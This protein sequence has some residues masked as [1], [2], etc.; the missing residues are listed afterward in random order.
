[1]FV[2]L[3][4]QLPDAANILTIPHSFTAYVNFTRST[5]GPRWLDCYSP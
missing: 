1:M 2:P 4:E 5:L 3:D